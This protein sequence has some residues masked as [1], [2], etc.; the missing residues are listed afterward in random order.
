MEEIK[1]DLESLYG[2]IQKMESQGENVGPLKANVQVM[3][4]KLLGRSVGSNQEPVQSNKRDSRRQSMRDSGSKAAIQRPDS[5]EYESKTLHNS[6]KSDT[7]VKQGDNLEKI[8]AIEATEKAKKIDEQK[9]ALFADMKKVMK[10][11]R[12]PSWEKGQPMAVGEDNKEA[13]QEPAKD[14]KHFQKAM[15]RLANQ[16]KQQEPAK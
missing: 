1:E 11:N 13:P 2:L 6:A 10:K 8:Q 5:V 3:M 9:K 14:D 7:E 16:E 12:E 15:I 4:N